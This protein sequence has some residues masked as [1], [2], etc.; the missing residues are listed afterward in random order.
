MAVGAQREMINAAGRAAQNANTVLDL[1]HLGIDCL[2][3]DIAGLPAQDTTRS[4]GGGTG[5]SPTEAAA[6]RKPDQA[7]Q[8]L[9]ELRRALKAMDNAS[10]K[11]VAILLRAV[12]VPDLPG[13]DHP[14]WWCAHCATHGHRTVPVHP[15]L[16]VCLWCHRWRQA[17]SMCLPP[18]E[19][20]EA[21]HEGKAITVKLLAKLEADQAKGKR[22]GRKGRKTDPHKANKAA[23]VKP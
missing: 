20:V 14:E 16:P 3:L 7:E 17:H 13:V 21:H 2:T 10:T 15:G 19:I 6:L 8:D 9:R 1:V 22:R 11:A 5:D 23:E 12:T 4:G 18:K